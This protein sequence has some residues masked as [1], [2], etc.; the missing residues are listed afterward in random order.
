MCLER[1]T[2]EGVPSAGILTAALHYSSSPRGGKGPELVPKL[3]SC[4]HR[5][6]SGVGTAAAR[7]FVAKKIDVRPVVAVGKPAR[8][9]VE[10]AAVNDVALG[11]AMATSRKRLG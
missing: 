5:R 11:L 1:A 9:I 8:G 4:G 2:D 6:V 3:G 7:R 10:H